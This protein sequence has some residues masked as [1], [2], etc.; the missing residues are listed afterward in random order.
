MTCPND[1]YVGTT[2]LVWV[3][4]YVVRKFLQTVAFTT[5]W[6]IED[7]NDVSKFDPRVLLGTAG[8]IGARLDSN[9][10]YLAQRIGIP[11]IMLNLI[12]EM[13]RC[14]RSTTRKH[15]DVT[16]VYHFV[17][18]LKEFVCLNER[19]CLSNEE[20]IVENALSS[21]SVTNNGEDILSKEEERETQQESMLTSAQFFAWMLVDG[22]NSLNMNVIIQLHCIAAT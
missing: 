14:G 10:V 4:E 19:L 6:S 21:D 3:K 7:I 5:T 9:D 20:D 2:A 17:W 18:N 12:K 15:K 22:I 8:C 1:G 11:T 16:N 13:G